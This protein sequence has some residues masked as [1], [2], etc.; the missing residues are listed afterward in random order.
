MRILF[1]EDP[2]TDHRS[3]LWRAPHIAL[4]ASWMLTLLDAGHDVRMVLGTPLRT[5]ASEANLPPEKVFEVEEQAIIVKLDDPHLDVNRLLH[6]YHRRPDCVND[7]RSELASTTVAILRRIAEETLGDFCPEIIIT[8]VPVP[9]LRELFPDALILHKETGVTSRSPFAP[10]YYLDPLGFHDRSALA[11]LNAIVPS[12]S[13]KSAFPIYKSALQRTLTQTGDCGKWIDRRR[14]FTQSILLATQVSG[15][16]FF[17]GA[18]SYRSQS[19][20]VLDV[21]DAIGRDVAVLVTQHPDHPWMRHC[22]AQFFEHSNLILADDLGVGGSQY[23]LPHVDAV[24]T[25][26]SSVGLQASLW[27]RPLVALGSSHLNRLTEYVGPE[28]I[29]AALRSKT[30]GAD[31]GAWLAFHYCY[32]DSWVRRPGWLGQHLEAKLRLWREHGLEGYFAEPLADP[33]DLTDAALDAIE[34]SPFMPER[35]NGVE[36]MVYA[37]T[38]AVVFNEG[39]TAP[40]HAGS[41]PHRWLQGIEGDL[42]LPLAAGQ[43]QE[44]ALTISPLAGIVGQW[45][46]LTVGD[47]QIGSQPLIANSSIQIKATVPASL[48]ERPFTKIRVKAIRADVPASGGGLLSIITDHVSVSP[49]RTPHIAR[50]KN[51][52]HSILLPVLNGLSLLQQTVSGLLAFGPED[53][54][55]IISD[56]KSDD[57]TWDF[58]NS[59]KDSR[60]VK[61]CTDER[62]DYASNA[63]NA[64]R[65]ARGE[66][67]SHIGDDDLIVPSR[68]P[69]IEQLALDRDID[70]IFGNRIRY[71]WPGFNSDLGNTADS[72]L[73]GDHAVILGG[74]EAARRMINCSNVRHTGATVI[75]RSLVEKVRHVTGGP[76]MIQRIGE[77][78][79]FRIAAGLAQKAAF[80]N[81][82]IVAIG[83]H[84]KSIGTSLFHDASA[85]SQYGVDLER[86]IGSLHADSGYSYLGFQA[87][88]YEGAL[89]AAN[90]L[91]PHIGE[92]HVDYRLWQSRLHLELQGLVAQGRLTADTGSVVQ[93]L[94]DARI[95]QL[96][97]AQNGAFFANGTPQAIESDSWGI[98]RR[99]HCCEVGVNSISQL[100][101][102]FEAEYADRL[103]GPITMR[104]VD[105]GPVAWIDM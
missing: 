65:H 64:Y 54:E 84:I 71:Y 75:H 105:A 45:V 99:L 97:A 39:W 6:R 88:S 78:A 20:L 98:N 13:A 41:A 74:P 34:R 58:I 25:V 101:A 68:F 95:A 91:R 15:T 82:P 29:A 70:I 33:A 30:D 43:N 18:C 21:L 22:D 85:G 103:A 17:D 55:L 23:L 94:G 80:V 59:L 12:S 69:L 92:C 87:F 7:A 40:I 14:E 31:V 24:A 10:S 3:M 96:V 77:Y 50:E 44:V 66:W 4:D 5:V 76:F 1:Y 90:L 73:F 60:I 86:E 53:M 27:N 62:V 38:D 9:H 26:S 51:P 52:T 104:S 49:A 89:L 2:L 56:N 93:A 36:K 72:V 46:T 32:L 81:R 28:S 42:L 79:S 11:S 83:R 61:I 35:A 37:A 100:V 102:W 63:E 8:W 19:H 67:I 48:I 47:H 16:F 57:Q